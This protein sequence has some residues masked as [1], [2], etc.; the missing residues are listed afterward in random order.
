M[1]CHQY[2]KASVSTSKILPKHIHFDLRP[3]KISYKAIFQ[4][5]QLGKTLN[6][7]TGTKYVSKG[8]KY[9]ECKH[10]T[11]GKNSAFRYVP[12]Q[13]L[14]QDALKTKTKTMHFKFMLPQMGSTLRVVIWAYGVPG[15]F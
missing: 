15:H 4:E 11:G 10:G 6:K 14:I 1:L 8:L 5:T 7:M 13:D 3:E 12:E 9:V 2:P